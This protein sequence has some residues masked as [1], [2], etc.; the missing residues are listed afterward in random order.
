M[1]NVKD[2]LYQFS[3]SGVL[4]KDPSLCTYNGRGVTDLYHLTQKAPQFMQGAELADKVVGKAAAA[5]IIKGGIISVYADVISTPALAM[6][7][8][9]G[10][11]TEY[12]QEVPFIA[13]RTRTG[14]CPLETL[15]EGEDAPELLYPIIGEFVQKMSEETEKQ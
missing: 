11:E 8:K 4:Q 13:N 6:L 3:C 12:A 10:I 5:L 9:A 15:C 7:R 2:V 1:L 14:M